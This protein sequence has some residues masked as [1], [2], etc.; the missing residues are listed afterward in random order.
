MKTL[1]RHKVAGRVGVNIE[2]LR[3]YEKKGLIPK[4][5]RSESNYRIYDEGVVRRVKFIKHA[6]ELGFS[7]REILELL[8][9]RA[10]PRSRCGGVRKKAEAKISEIE[11]KV[12]AL[13][14]MKRALTKLVQE[15]S[16]LGPA[17]ECPILRS[18][19]GTDM[20]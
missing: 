17:T 1:T 8:S 3:F 11:N 9:L 7:L 15:C 20:A 6:Q 13:K 19:D 18:I 16:S 5:D 10:A 12:K 14:S 4:P 2:T